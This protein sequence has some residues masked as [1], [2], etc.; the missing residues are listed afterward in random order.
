MVNYEYISHTLVPF[1]CI[2][3]RD[4]PSCAFMHIGKMTC[5]YDLLLRRKWNGRKNIFQGTP[6]IKPLTAAAASWRC[7]V[8]YASFHNFSLTFFSPYLYDLMPVLVFSSFVFCV[9]SNLHDALW[10]FLSL[11]LFLLISLFHN[12]SWSSRHVA[13]SWR[14]SVDACTWVLARAL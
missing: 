2:G 1:P 3:Q 14:G 4:W 12:L 9:S 10:T 5:F 7:G 11:I 8:L 6:L 13:Y